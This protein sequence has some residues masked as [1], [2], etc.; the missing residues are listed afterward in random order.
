LLGSGCCFSPIFFILLKWLRGEQTFTS[1][2][3]R[4]RFEEDWPFLI[5]KE[6]RLLAGEQSEAELRAAQG[7]F[8]QDSRPDRPE[9]R[10]CSTGGSAEGQAQF[11]IRLEACWLRLG[12]KTTGLQFCGE[13][14]LEFS[15]SAAT[16]ERCSGASFGGGRLTSLGPQPAWWP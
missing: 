11:W 3:D 8:G 13:R 1:R 2:I 14:L 16:L 10:L 12:D 6:S 15:A 7:S 4:S 9:R 5:L